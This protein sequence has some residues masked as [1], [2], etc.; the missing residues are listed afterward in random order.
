MSLIGRIKAFLEGWR[1]IKDPPKWVWKAYH[2]WE[3][4][5]PTHPYNMTK[6]FVGKNYIFRIR[7]GIGMQG[8]APIIGWYVKKK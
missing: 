7:H 5:L 6:H 2:R 3:R 8:E 1:E 4:K